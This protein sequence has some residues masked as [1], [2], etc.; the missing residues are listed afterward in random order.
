M[1]DAIAL[2]G[3]IC[4]IVETDERLDLTMLKVKSATFVW[5]LMITRPIFETAA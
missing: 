5:E 2:Q 4:S 1:A 3:K